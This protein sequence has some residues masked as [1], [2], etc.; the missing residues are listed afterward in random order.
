MLSVAVFIGT[1]FFHLL[2]AISMQFVDLSCS[3]DD[4]YDW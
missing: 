3:A 2:R 1:I 4:F